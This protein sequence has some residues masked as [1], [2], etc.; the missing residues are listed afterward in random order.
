M[1]VIRNIRALNRADAT[2]MKDHLFH[3]PLFEWSLFDSDVSL[4]RGRLRENNERFHSR[5][6]NSPSIISKRFDR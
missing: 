6:R 2:L 5:S 1:N 3:P 4:L